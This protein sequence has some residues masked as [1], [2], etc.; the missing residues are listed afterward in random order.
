MRKRKLRR[1]FI[2]PVMIR[3]MKPPYITRLLSV[4]FSAMLIYFL[5][6]TLAPSVMAAIDLDQQ[7]DSLSKKLTS[8]SKGEVL[9]STDSQVYISLGLNQGIQ[10]GNRFEIIRQGEALKVDDE[11]IGWEETKIAEV[12][13]SR[14]RDRVSICKILEKTELPKV[15]DKAYQLRKNVTSI[16]VAQFSY[17]Q[18]F[19]QLTKNLQ[20]KLFT[21][22]SNR[23]MQVTERDQLEKVLKE[24]KLGYSGLININSAKKIGNLLGADGIMLGT[25]ND[26]GDAIN[27]NARIVDLE[28]GKA[29]T[30]AEVELPKTPLIVQL[31]DTLVEDKP[32]VTGSRSDSQSHNKAGKSPKISTESGFTSALKI[33]KRRADSVTCSVLI[34]NNE[35]NRDFILYKKGSRMFDKSGNEYD[36]SKIQLGSCERDRGDCRKSLIQGIPTKAEI[37]FKGV[38]QETQ[39]ATALDLSCWGEG[40]DR[41]SFQLRDI[42]L[43]Q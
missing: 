28:I 41:F 12:E 21:A 29:I 39:I 27:I 5:L 18:A 10:P 37:S 42:P 35:K 9:K 13:V 14:A 24:Q 38:L 4:Y 3:G 33:C 25:V 30:A 8:F 6:L 22:M 17:N 43:V 20:D 11:I 32:F 19:N 40:S 31:L 1:V 7:V 2:N 16:V 23:G 26:M 15:G 34:T 36:A